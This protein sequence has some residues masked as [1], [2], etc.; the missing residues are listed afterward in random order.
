M[1][2]APPPPAPSRSQKTKGGTGERGL[3]SLMCEG[4]GVL[5]LILPPASAGN[6]VK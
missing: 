6:S 4:I 5:L 1:R 3:W 2:P